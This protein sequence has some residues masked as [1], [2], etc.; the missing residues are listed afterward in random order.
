MIAIPLL[1]VFAVL[2]TVGQRIAEHIARQ[3]D[4]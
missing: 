4:Q 3:E 2:A 1:I